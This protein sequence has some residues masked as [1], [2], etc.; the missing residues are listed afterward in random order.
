MSTITLDVPAEDVLDALSDDDLIEEAGRRG[1][2]TVGGRWEPPRS[3]DDLVAELRQAFAARDATHFEVLL[4]RLATRPADRRGLPPRL[5][6][7]LFSSTAAE[8]AAPCR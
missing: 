2:T 5:K 6:G 7:D 4:H 8:P 1:L 3:V